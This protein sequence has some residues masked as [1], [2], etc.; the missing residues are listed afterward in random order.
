VNSIGY[1]ASLANPHADAAAV[2][3]DDGDDTERKS[4]AAL[5]HIRNPRDIYDVF[6]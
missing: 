3:T 2:V 4:A 5:D 6:I 1:A